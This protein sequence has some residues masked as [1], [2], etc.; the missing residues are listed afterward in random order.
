MSAHPDAFARLAR[1]LTRTKDRVIQDELLDKWLDYLYLATAWDAEQWGFDPE[2]WMQKE[3][4]E[5][6]SR[7]MPSVSDKVFPRPPRG[8]R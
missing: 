7:A 1:D 2:G 5:L 4:A 6:C 8:V 3:R